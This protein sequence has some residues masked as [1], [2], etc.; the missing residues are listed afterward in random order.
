MESSKT[1]AGIIALLSTRGWVSLRQFALLTDVSYPTA[2]RLADEGKVK[3]YKVGGI[4]RVDAD[5]LARF[6][7]EG[8]AKD[9][10]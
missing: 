7:K 10:N 1:N 4:R 9:T 3:T 5:E 6:L 8:N 2:V